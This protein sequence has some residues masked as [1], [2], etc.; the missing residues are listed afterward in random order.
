MP[1]LLFHSVV[2]RPGCEMS[3]FPLHRFKNFCRELAARNY[4]GIL[5][6]NAQSITPTQLNDKQVLITFDDGLS[7]FYQYA[8][9][10]LY[11]IG[12]KTTI[13]CLG[14][15]FN[16]FS[17]WDVYPRNLHLSKQE[18]RE[19][20]D[21]GYEIGSHTMTHPCLPYL[22]DR[23][24]KSELTDSRKALEDV[25]GTSITSLSFPYGAWNRKVWNI[26]KESGYSA[27]TLY[28]GKMLH[29][30]SLYPVVGA[31][32]Y[33]TVED[34]IEK[35]ESRYPFSPVLAYSKMI[36]HFSRGTPLWK[37]RKE[38]VRV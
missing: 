6:R 35:I 17:T 8:F 19:I 29:G 18:I 10:V 28:R 27:A 3:H 5:V 31:Y 24:I 34:I 37:Y 11:E 14:S 30:E 4:N 21:C 32:K 33:D 38:Y 15:N 1:G 2:P 20:A 7:S 25:T 16:E 12:I 13:F 22:D 26:A 36:S 9:P 23:S